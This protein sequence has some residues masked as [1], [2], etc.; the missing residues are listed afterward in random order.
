MFFGAHWIQNVVLS[1]IALSSHY[2]P[3][4]IVFIFNSLLL[5]CVL[6]DDLFFI[7][8]FSRYCMILCFYMFLWFAEHFAMVSV[9]SKFQRFLFIQIYLVALISVLFLLTHTLNDANNG[10]SY[11]QLLFFSSILLHM[12]HK[13]YLLFRLSTRAIRIDFYIREKRTVFR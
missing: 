6:F 3:H 9:C 13:Y 1:Y 5:W 7:F 12:Q 8:S 4:R 10:R 11:A 2:Q